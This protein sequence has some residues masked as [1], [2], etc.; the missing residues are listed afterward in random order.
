MDGYCVAFWSVINEWKLVGW[1]IESA[2]D[3]RIH[4][5]HPTLEDAIEAVKSTFKVDRG[6]V[7]FGLK[8]N[9]WQEV[10]LDD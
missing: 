2:E 4:C 7:V 8:T 10:K 1:S 6:Y 9:V 3:F 5:I